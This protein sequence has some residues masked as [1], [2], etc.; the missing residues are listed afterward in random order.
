MPQLLVRLALV[1]YFHASLVVGNI[2]EGSL[3]PWLRNAI[4]KFVAFCRT[5]ISKCVLMCI[6]G[7]KC[8]IYAIYASYMHEVD[9]FNPKWPVTPFSGLFNNPIMDN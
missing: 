8:Y 2:L 4:A 3:I 6:Q 9:V 7:T 1:C 5:T